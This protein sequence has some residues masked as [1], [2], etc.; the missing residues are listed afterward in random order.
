VVIEIITALL[1]PRTSGDEF[2]KFPYIDFEVTLAIIPEA[3]RLPRTDMMKRLLLLYA[4][5]AAALAGSTAARADMITFATGLT[6]PTGNT[7]HQVDAQA[8][9]TITKGA[10]NVDTISIQIENL[11]PNPVADNQN[12]NGIIFTFTKN[13]TGTTPVTL[14]SSSGVDRTIAGNKTYSDVATATTDWNVSFSSPKVTLTAIGNPAAEQ[15][16]IGG[17]AADNKYDAANGSLTKGNHDPFLAGDTAARAP[18]FTLTV[19]GIDPTAT[20]ASVMF[21]FGTNDTTS[22]VATGHVVP[23][24]S[25]LALCAVG[26]AAALGYVRRRKSTR[27]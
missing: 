2:T 11:L 19:T 7:G 20:I 16:V 4:A 12:I 15:T 1:I 3:K 22:V 25:S 24:P 14:T 5:T 21:A 27:C 26:L 8:T 18:I 10:G 9:F 17:P 13:P 6:T 23:E